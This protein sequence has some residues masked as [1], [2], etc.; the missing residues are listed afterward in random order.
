M[1]EKGIILTQYGYLLILTIFLVIDVD[2][3]FGFYLRILIALMF[4]SVLF[5]KQGIKRFYRPIEIV[6]IIFTIVYSIRFIFDIF[7]KDV[8]VLGYTRSYL[9]NY[10]FLLII[11]PITSIINNR[12]RPNI[13]KFISYLWIFTIL[14]NIFSVAYFLVNGLDIEFLYSSRAE[15]RS[16]DGNS[17][18]L[19]PITIGH[20]GVSL[21]LQVI[22][23]FKNTNSLLILLLVPFGIINLLISASRGPIMILLIILFL[24]I[25]RKVISKNR[26]WIMILIGILFTYLF[27]NY[28]FINIYQN[29][30]YL[31][32]RLLSTTESYGEESRFIIWNSA[33][34]D[35]LNNPIFGNSIVTNGGSYPHNVFL[36][37]LMSTGVIGFILFIIIFS[38]L[39]FKTSKKI[40]FSNFNNEDYINIWWLA[41]FLSSLTSGA[42]FFNPILWISTIYILK[43]E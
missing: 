42:L 5:Q 7:L 3:S 8:E 17:T 32:N 19:N 39:I 15:V 36:E 31:I 20:L 35:F 13:K 41:I 18:I 11:L 30:V 23:R 34:N 38:Y 2:F 16:D 27:Y 28:F 43:N 21:L 37:I 26:N 14:A 25:I 10:F 24:I 4:L 1:Q 40:I 33:L 12:K 6:F 22:W 29:D 9:I